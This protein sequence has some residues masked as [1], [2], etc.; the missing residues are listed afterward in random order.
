MQHRILAFFIVFLAATPAAA[1]VLFDA[2]GFMGYVWN[3]WG[4]PDPGTPAVIHWSFMSAD[5]AGSAYCGE[6][7]PGSSGT[8][9]QF[10]NPATDQFESRQLSELQTQIEAA[11]TTWAAAA[12]IVFVGPVDDSGLP[13]NDE[14]A[15]PPAS[16]HVRIGAFAFTGGA[17][18]LGAVGY[19]PPPNGGTGAGEILFNSAAFFQFAAGQEDVTPINFFFGNDFASLF[20][21][22]AGHALGLAHSADEQSVMYIDPAGEYLINRELASDDVAGIEILYGPAADTDTDGVVDVLDNCLNLPNEDQRDTD[23]D[24]IG[25]RCDPDFNGDCLVNFADLAI[26]SADFFQQG[27][28]DTD[29]N[30]DSI[31]NFAD[32]VVVADYFFLAPG[33]SGRANSCS[34]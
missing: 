10:Y 33:P 25:N 15:L 27:D 6:A 20:L 26:L 17:T 12:D 19:A 11:L 9:L 22:E 3:K 23:L 24:A 5:T 21:H 1:F 4:P 2:G 34:Q 13:I 32:L 7:C 30:G 18:F 16:G 14:A 28:L 8:T 29:L 31:V